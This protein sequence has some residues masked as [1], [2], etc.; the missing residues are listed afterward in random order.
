MRWVELFSSVIDYEGGP[1]T[2]TAVLDITERKMAEEEHRRLERDLRQ[3]QKM[4]AIGTL[5][6]GI[7]H[8][9]NNL[10]QAI[11]GYTQLGLMGKDQSHPDY[12]GFKAILKA[13]NRAAGL[14]RQML[15]FST[16]VEADR[17][18]HGCQQKRWRKRANCWC[19]ASPRWW[20]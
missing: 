4:E 18:A 15:L 20:K 7:A 6:G 17:Q 14:V 11:N 19:A 1:A 3:A 13:G 5:A 10:L 2:Q 8:D 12:A 9:F 16:K